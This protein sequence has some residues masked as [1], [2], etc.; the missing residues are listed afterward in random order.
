MD[1]FTKYAEIAAIEN[2]EAKTVARCFLERYICRFSCPERVVSNC[3]MEFCNKIMVEL[4]KLMGIQKD[5]MS[6]Y[7]PQSN[8]SAESF[9]RSLIKYLRAVLDNDT[10]GDWER[11]LPFCS[12]AYNS[13]VHKSMLESPFFLTFLHDPRLPYFDLLEP[14]K[15]YG[16]S[17]TTEA[18]LNMS[19]SFIKL[20]LYDAMPF[21]KTLKKHDYNRKKT[22]KTCQ[23]SSSRKKISKKTQVKFQKTYVR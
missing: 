22:E 16:D 10:T 23:L 1:A 11:W 6:S 7:H 13:H 5:R 21:Q 12:L 20:L 3:G 14:R 8:S 17:Y 9:N 4:F 19:Q 15:M 2:K 18:F